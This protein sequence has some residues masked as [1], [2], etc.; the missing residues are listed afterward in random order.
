MAGGLLG[1]LPPGAGATRGGP[2]LSLSL[3]AP[4]FTLAHLN[5][6]RRFCSRLNAS[7][8][9]IFS[10]TSF[11]FLKYSFIRCACFLRAMYALYS[12]DQSRLL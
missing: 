9:D 4:I 2:R 11:S 3:K 12:A 10:F 6:F 8:I 1:N 7:I 5:T